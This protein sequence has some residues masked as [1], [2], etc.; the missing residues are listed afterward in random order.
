MTARIVLASGRQEQLAPF[1]DALG[2]ASGVE[3]LRL[4]SGREALDAVQP[5]SVQLAVVDEVLP[6]MA[7]LELVRRLMAVDA[8][9]QTAF[10]S[11]LGEE[12]F[13]HRSEGL[14]ILMQ[15]PIQ[16]GAGDAERL[17]QA[18]EATRG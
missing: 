13:H 8:F 4:P 18:L 5:R 17:L 15:L 14:G 2:A 1:A 3:L 16:P 11:D 10:L 12:A 7:G 9:I 6:D